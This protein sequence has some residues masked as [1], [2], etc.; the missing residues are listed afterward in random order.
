MILSSVDEAY[1]NGHPERRL[2][3]NLN[4]S[5]AYVEGESVLMGLNKEVALSSGLGLHLRHARAV[6][7]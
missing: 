4:I 7:T 1:L 3:G 5:F 6:A 2:P